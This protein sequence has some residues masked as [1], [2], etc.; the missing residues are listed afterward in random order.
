MGRKEMERKILNDEVDEC[1]IRNVRYVYIY[2]AC[3]IVF[4]IL[5]IITT[6]IHHRFYNCIVVINWYILYLE[7]INLCYYVCVCACAYTFT[8]YTFS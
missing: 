6:L 3:C 7:D 4:T 2:W 1:K 5:F 8:Y